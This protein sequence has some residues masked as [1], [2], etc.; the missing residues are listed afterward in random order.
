MKL[1]FMTRVANAARDVHVAAEQEK[2]RHA[3]EI[4][5]HLAA[6]KLRIAD[7]LS[8]LSVGALLHGSRELVFSKHTSYPVTA[9]ARWL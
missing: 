5:Q 7:K 3:V 8:K 2:E 6:A 4:E 9:D 1:D